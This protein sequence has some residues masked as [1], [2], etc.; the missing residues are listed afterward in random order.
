MCTLKN[1]KRTRSP[2]MDELIDKLNE[3]EGHILSLQTEDREMI[4]KVYHKS[5]TRFR[6]KSHKE[7][8]ED[9]Y[10]KTYSLEEQNKIQEFTN[11][12]CSIEYIAKKLSRS[13]IGVKQ[14]LQK[15]IVTKNP[16]L[17]N[18]LVKNFIPLNPRTEFLIPQ[19][20]N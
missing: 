14:Q 11:Q 16:I 6:K 13:P 12:G 19:H 17:S 8:G 5:L 18:T 9:N 2:T 15:L 20:Q 10:G 4:Q 3:L 7:H 1:T